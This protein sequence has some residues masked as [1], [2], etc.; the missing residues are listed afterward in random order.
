MSRRG[1]LPPTFFL[2]ALFLEAALHFGLP[3]ASLVTTPWS[4]LGAIPILV[5]L[6]VMVVGD[7]QFKKAETAISPFDQPSTLVR[8]GVFRISRNPM[9]VGMVLTLAGEAVVLGTVTPMLVPWIFVWLI[10]SRFI[11]MEETVLSGVFGAEY[12]DYRRRVRR[13]L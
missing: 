3:V 13:W 8:G 11:R 12:E 9:Y 7:R 4:W 2:G 6:V 10:S 1:P 5:G